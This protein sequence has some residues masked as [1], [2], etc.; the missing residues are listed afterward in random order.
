MHVIQHFFYF[1]YIFREY[2]RLPKKRVLYL[3]MIFIMIKQKLVK[4][5]LEVNQRPLESD[6]HNMIANLEQRP[7]DMVSCLIANV[8]FV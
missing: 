7:L 6:D 8:C 3:D 1:Q 5:T 4:V 2:Y